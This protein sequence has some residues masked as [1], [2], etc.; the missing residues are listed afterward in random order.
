[1]GSASAVP[2]LPWGTGDGDEARAVDRE[3]RP[4][5]GRPRSQRGLRASREAVG[6]RVREQSTLVRVRTGLFAH[7][8]LRRWFEAQACTLLLIPETP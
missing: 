3:R 1:M 6:V 7:R 4:C 2:D 8:A 5:R